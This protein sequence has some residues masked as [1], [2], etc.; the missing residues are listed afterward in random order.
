MPVK[1]KRKNKVFCNECAYIRKNKK[2][3]IDCYHC[4]LYDRDAYNQ[5]ELWAWGK[6]KGNRTG[7]CTYFK[8]VSLLILLWRKLFGKTKEGS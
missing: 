7:D 3:Q 1:I 5:D 2:S 6:F 8:R 4:G